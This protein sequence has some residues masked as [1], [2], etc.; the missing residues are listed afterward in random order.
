MLDVKQQEAYCSYAPQI[1]NSFPLFSTMIRK[2]QD[3]KMSEK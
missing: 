2:R 1:T 3:S